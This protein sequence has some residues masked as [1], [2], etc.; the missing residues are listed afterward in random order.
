[1]SENNKKLGALWLR[2]KKNSDD[3]FLKGEIKIDDSTIK[4]SVFKNSYKTKENQPDYVIY[5]AQEQENPNAPKPTG[6]SPF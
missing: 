6:D 2:T 4:I 5:E 1:M 3:K